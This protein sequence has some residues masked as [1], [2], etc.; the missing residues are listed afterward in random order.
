MNIYIVR[1]QTEVAE[2]NICK[3]CR[4]FT[5]LSLL[6]KCNF[7]ML[8]DTEIFKTYR[9]IEIKCEKWSGKNTWKCIVRV[10]HISYIYMKIRTENQFSLY[11]TNLIFPV[12]QKFRLQVPTSRIPVS[13]EAGTIRNRVAHEAGWTDRSLSAS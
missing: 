11:V 13:Q 9:R 4:N 3:H 10:K 1:L 8:Q 12:K 2:L 7:W 5:Y 6:G